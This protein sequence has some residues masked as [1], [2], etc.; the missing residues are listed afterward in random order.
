MKKTKIGYPL[1][2]KQTW[3]LSTIALSGGLT[4][5]NLERLWQRLFWPERIIPLTSYDSFNMRQTLD[6]LVKANLLKKV[7]DKRDITLY[8]IS[9]TTP[10]VLTVGQPYRPYSRRV[11]TFLS[12]RY[13]GDKNGS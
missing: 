10:G 6:S 1:T 13:L 7:K 8:Q 12:S 11:M 2:T 5:Y 3:I 9:S 4:K